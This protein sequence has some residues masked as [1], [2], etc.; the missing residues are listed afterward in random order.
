MSI[1][2]K[3]KPDNMGFGLGCFALHPSPPPP[4][5][6]ELLLAGGRYQALGLAIPVQGASSCG[7]SFE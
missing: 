7:G 6:A 4:D 1:W 3:E 2:A 5:P